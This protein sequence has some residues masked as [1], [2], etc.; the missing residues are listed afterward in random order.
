MPQLVQAVSVLATDPVAQK[1]GGQKE[2]NFVA[3]NRP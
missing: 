2:R 3:I 1:A